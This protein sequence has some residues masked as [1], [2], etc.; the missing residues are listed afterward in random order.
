MLKLPPVSEAAAEGKVAQTYER[1]HDLLGEAPLPEPFLYMGAVEPF[2]R[3]FY[4]NSK[5]FVFSDGKL[6]A[7][8][9]AAIALVTALHAHCQPWVDVFKQRC[10]DAGWSETELAEITAISTTNYMYNT[11]FKFRSLGGTDRFEGLPVGLRAHTFSGTSL[12]DKLVELLNLVISDL[13]ACGPCVSGHVSK[14]EQLGLS[15]E[16]M[17]EAIQCAATVYAGAQFTN[18]AM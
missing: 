4:M 13:N 9:K 10:L 3:D 8:T 16:A 17:L 1:L 6:D 2:L 14:A 11:F 12:D 18:A 7:R 5:K 15:H